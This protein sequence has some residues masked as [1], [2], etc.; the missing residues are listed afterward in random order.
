MTSIG[1]HRQKN[2][3]LAANKPLAVLSLRLVPMVTTGTNG[4]IYSGKTPNPTSMT[5][6]FSCCSIYPLFILE[7][8]SSIK[9]RVAHCSLMIV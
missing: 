2:Q 8:T 6:D 3:P 9:L 1:C 5:H 4:K 7:G